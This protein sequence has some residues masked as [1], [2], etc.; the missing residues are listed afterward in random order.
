MEAFAPLP[1]TKQTSNNF[2]IYY[3]C[4][5]NINK[6]ILKDCVRNLFFLYMVSF[7]QFFKH[8][9]NIPYNL[10]IQT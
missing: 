6:I 2:C 9:F 7:S 10:H 5:T 3:K 1:S 8:F 4:N